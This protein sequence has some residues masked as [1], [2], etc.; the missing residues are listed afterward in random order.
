[1][2]FLRFRSLLKT[3]RYLKTG[4]VTPLFTSSLMV[5]RNKNF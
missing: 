5:S 2:F 1:M 4:K 3:S